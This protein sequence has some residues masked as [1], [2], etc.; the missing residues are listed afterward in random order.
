MHPV[1]ETAA[2][3]VSSVQ[4]SPTSNRVASASYGQVLKSSALVG[5]SSIIEIV[6]RIVRTKAMALLVGPAGI[7]L[8]GIYI[9]ITELVR[10]LA[11]MGLK[12]SGVRQ[13]AEAVGTGDDLRVAR[14]VQTLRRL[15]LISGAAGGL[16]LLASARTVSSLTFGD[17]GRAGA[18]A[19]LALSVPLSDI[20][21]ARQPWFRGCA[22]SPTWHV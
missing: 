4:A 9:A 16:L 20:S 12:T 6:F 8:L 17:A 13:I 7:G 22:G 15:A 21:D 19:L 11:G 3:T 5:G 10:N 1:T 14:T 2:P 18:I